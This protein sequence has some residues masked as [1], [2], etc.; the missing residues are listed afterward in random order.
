MR[1]KNTFANE[2]QRERHALK[3]SRNNAG[4]HKGGPYGKEFAIIPAAAKNKVAPLPL[5]KGVRVQ[6]IMLPGLRGPGGTMT[7]EIGEDVMGSIRRM[8]PLP[9][10]G[11]CKS[12][13]ISQEDAAAVLDSLEDALYE[14]EE[15]A[16]IR[17]F[18]GG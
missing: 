2:Q 4:R 9:S 10:K 15:L 12:N 7:M 18:G 17:E 13:Q 6:R 3:A 5:T 1:G 8:K 11:Y 14:P 16:A